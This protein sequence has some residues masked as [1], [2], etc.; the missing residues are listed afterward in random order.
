[1]DNPSIFYDF[2]MDNKQ[3][4]KEY[5]DKKHLQSNGS[6]GVLITSLSFDLGIDYKEIL[7]ILKELYEEKAIITRQGINGKLI[8]KK[9]V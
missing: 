6:C 4:V 5:I 7:P 8:F 2:D 9:I 3:I 1:M